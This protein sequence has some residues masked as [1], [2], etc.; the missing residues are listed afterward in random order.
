M[1]IYDKKLFLKPSSIF[2]YN[3]GNLIKF[4]TVCIKPMIRKVKLL[5][6]MEFQEQLC[7]TFKSKINI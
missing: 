4:C 3:M 2:L 5:F 1:I 7:Y 6:Y